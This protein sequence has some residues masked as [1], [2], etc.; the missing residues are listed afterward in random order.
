MNFKHLIKSLL[1]LFLFS[2][3]TLLGQTPPSLPAFN[4]DVLFADFDYTGMS[5][6]FLLDKAKEPIIIK[7]LK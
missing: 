7:A 6:A 2:T 5:T 3:G 4:P 1:L